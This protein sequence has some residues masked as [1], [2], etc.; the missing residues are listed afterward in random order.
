MNH[1]SIAI[2]R[3]K[4]NVKQD[5]F[6]YLILEENGNFKFF[7][8]VN[9]AMGG[10]FDFSSFKKQ[11]IKYFNLPSTIEI[12]RVVVPVDFEVPPVPFKS[13][14]RDPEATAYL[15]ELSQPQTDAINK[16]IEKREGKWAHIKWVTEVELKLS[17]PWKSTQNFLFEKESPFKPPKFSN[18][19]R[20]SLKK[21]VAAKNNGKLVIFAGAGVSIDS[22]VPGWGTLISELKNDLA[23]D[24]TDFLKVAE[25]YYQARG[26]KEYHEKVQEILK[27]GKTK[28]NP[29]HRKVTQ[30][31]P[32]HIV[33]TNYDTHFEQLL[34]NK[35]LPYSVIRADSDF[36]YSK[37]SSLFV[38]MHGDFSLRNI[39]LRQTDYDSYQD[40]FS[41]IQSFIRETFASKLVL[42]I[43]FS[44]SDENLRHILESV[45]KILKKDIQQPYLFNNL[46][47][48]PAV[49]AMK[50][51]LQKQGVR[52]LQFESALNDYFDQVKNGEDE[53]SLKL[54]SV[55]SQ[56]VYKFLK[57]IEEFDLISDSLENL[58]IKNQF[59]HS[60]ERFEGLGAIPLDVLGFTTPFK[61][62]QHP[63]SQSK[64]NAEFN[65]YDPF[66]LETLNEELLSFLN[67]RKNQQGEIDF[68]TYRDTTLSEE[69]Q[70]INRYFKLVYS[71][72][73]H[74]IR[75]KSDTESNHLRLNPINKKDD[76]C[77]CVR[78]LHDRFDVKKLIYSLNSTSAKAM[79]R[80]DFYDQGLLEAYGFLKTGQI[81]KAFYSLEEVRRESLKSEQ[82][83]TYFI[84]SYNQTLMPAMLRV[85]YE[86]TYNEDEKDR[87]LEKIE[88]I[89]LYQILHD[90][91][92]AQD[93]KHCLRIIME[94]DVY[95]RMLS[96]M[97]D[98]L[99]TIKETHASYK[100]EGHYSMGPNYWYRFQAYFWLTLNFYHQNLL[101]TDENYSFSKMA[102]LYLEGM[103]ASFTTSDRYSQKLKSFPPF[104][105]H[106]FIMYGYASD[107]T[108]LLKNYEVKNL[109]LD[110]DA[111]VL[112]KDFGLFLGSGYEKSTFFGERISR[113]TSYHAL[114]ESS[115]YFKNRTTRTF[116]NFLILLMH[117]KLQ[118]AEVNL[119]IRQMLDFLSVS[120]LFD[121]SD[122]HK[123]FSR[124]I[125]HYIEVIDD[126][127]IQKL[128]FY[129]LSDNVWS[130]SM[131]GSFCNAL[132][133]ARK[134]SSIFDED[135]YLKL[136]RRIE[137][138]KQWTV[139]VS[140]IIP[141]YALLKP[142]QQEKLAGL[143][144]T[145]LGEGNNKRWDLINTAY[146][147]KMWNPEKDKELFAEFFD[148]V[149]KLAKNFPDYTISD[150][151]QPNGKNF[152][153]WNDL[154]LTLH[155]IYSYKLFDLPFVHNL[156]KEIKSNM[157]KWILKPGEF[158]YALFELK[159]ILVFPGT[160][161]LE[162]LR[163]NSNLL[164]AIE[165]RLKKTYNAQ[166]AE[167]FYT[168]LK[169][170]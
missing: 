136:S 2:I 15:Y 84:A 162:V 23:T 57:V 55:K 99:E 79:C 118:E 90:L 125:K 12:D 45:E 170:L 16:E 117:V 122:S 52:L 43:G 115:V 10:T 145:H 108:K 54:L 63:K 133:T 69:D 5:H 124:F 116:N 132:I 64:V 6:D 169:G 147:W 11:I 110:D 30:L 164:E 4:S 160:D 33:T 75:R 149:L 1:L 73:V 165:M 58:E 167:L 156:H 134:V 70:K 3:K 157:F 107:T 98:E 129:I 148:Y 78:C 96:K 77:D 35:G 155:M 89:D 71:S 49:T 80:R 25:L 92:T 106:V 135:L 76:Q 128:G 42:F 9:V 28:Y 53:D 91:P 40:Q 97:E 161:F 46:D 67:G 61:L 24:E 83:I 95:K 48:E 81:I 138:K 105:V 104:F 152:Q 119:L 36:P 32:V 94:N 60:L 7:E 123:Y 20:A 114:C 151:G 103:V 39:V 139:S 101:F 102:Y 47:S 121:A 111:E 146:H 26:E 21:I 51:A 68:Y 143:I 22:Q 127:N 82:Y 14:K 131:I 109:T 168:K 59:I 29:L 34:E 120:E 87:I 163:N 130:G 153:P 65:Y 19:F 137:E 27:H 8:T 159:W 140:Q 150:D 93:I 13:S 31:K 37:G 74:C 166:A 41:L 88:S 18:D 66:H 141:F 38:K 158:D 144:I 154:Y 86:T 62:K 112:V 17:H 44:F 50:E 56:G 85:F 113:D 126:S 72:G 100:R 142:T